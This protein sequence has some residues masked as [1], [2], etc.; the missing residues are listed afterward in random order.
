MAPDYCYYCDFVIEWIQIK[1]ENEF[2]INFTAII[3]SIEF[4]MLD[5][6]WYAFHDES[7]YI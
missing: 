6:E 4:K 3:C 1:P 7:W 5:P 2:A